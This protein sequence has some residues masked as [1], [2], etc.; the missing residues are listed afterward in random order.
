M[1]S[2]CEANHIQVAESTAK[3]LMENPKYKLTKRGVLFVKGKGHLFI[4]II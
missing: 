3:H 2:N 4:I 1:Q